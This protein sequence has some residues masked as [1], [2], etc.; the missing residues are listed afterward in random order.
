MNLNEPVS[1]EDFSKWVLE[2]SRNSLMLTISEPHAK[3]KKLGLTVE[4]MQPIISK[5]IL[6]SN[7]SV[8]T[9]HK[10]FD[11]LRGVVVCENVKK[12]PHFHILFKKPDEIS[13]EKF[14]ARLNKVANKLCNPDFKFDLSHSYLKWEAKFLL[15]NPCYDKFAKV[16]NTHEFTGRY[17]TKQYA[18]Y[19]VLTDRTINFLNNQLHIFVKV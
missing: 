8:F 14:E 2:I 13:F 5:I 3:T 17:L 6:M 19:Y 15:S 10:H 16:T 18:Y 12:Q 11:F 4:N 9:K 7:N 1:K